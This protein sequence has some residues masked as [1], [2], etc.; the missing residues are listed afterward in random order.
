MRAPC[1]SRMKR[2]STLGSQGKE[3]REIRAEDKGMRGRRDS[4]V[5]PHGGLWPGKITQHLC[6]VCGA[7][8]FRG[9]AHVEVC[10]SH[11]G[12]FILSLRV[13]I[14][15]PCHL[16]RGP[17]DPGRGP[18]GSACKQSRTPTAPAARMGFPCQLPPVGDKEGPGT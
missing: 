16:P 8:A 4:N 11:R 1:A 7:G 12:L 3:T 17:C 14:R 13:A 6:V 5:L 15:Q 10:G 18:W 2:G 9:T